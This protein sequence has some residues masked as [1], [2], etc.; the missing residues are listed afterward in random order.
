MYAHVH[1][2]LKNLQV[3]VI[4]F[5][6]DRLYRFFYVDLSIWHSCLWLLFKKLQDIVAIG[7]KM[8]SS[9]G[10]IVFWIRVSVYFPIHK[11]GDDNAL[12]SYIS[13]IGWSNLYINILY[14][15]FIYYI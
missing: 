7:L 10:H 8:S 3:Q 6:I 1:L 13:L 9:F 15:S 14:M 11:C 2:I 5:S 12:Y 4:L